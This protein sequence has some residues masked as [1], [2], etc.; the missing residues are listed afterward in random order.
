MGANYTSPLL[1]PRTRPEG[2]T[3]YLPT[4]ASFAAG[5]L[6]QPWAGGQRVDARRHPREHPPS[7]GATR[8]VE[9]AARAAR[10]K[11]MALSGLLWLARHPREVSPH[12][13]RGRLHL[14]ARSKVSGRPGAGMA[15]P[16]RPACAWPGCA[17][18][19]NVESLESIRPKCVNQPYCAASTMY[20]PACSWRM[21]HVRE[22]GR[23]HTTGMWNF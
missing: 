19:G 1:R 16:G 3:A 11:G 12:A 6:H 20:R 8:A 9:Q 14:G 13:G 18:S 23:C 5:R 2:Q 22:T 17:T 4:V 7:R 15:T 10:S 21:A